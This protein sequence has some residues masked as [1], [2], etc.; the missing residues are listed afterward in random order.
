MTRYQG[1]T[2]ALTT[3]TAAMLASDNEHRPRAD[4]HDISPYLTSP[5]PRLGTM[6]TLI[7]SSRLQNQVLLKS[8]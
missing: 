5:A 8:E 2:Y 6:Y 7:L 1:A 4:C 3:T